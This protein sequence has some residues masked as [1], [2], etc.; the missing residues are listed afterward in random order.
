ME[1]QFLIFETATHFIVVLSCFLVYKKTKELY[2]L[3]LQKGLKYFY[4]AFWYY[5][6][7]FI[8]RYLL[9]IMESYKVEG[10]RLLII[11]FIVLYCAMV[12]GFYLAYSL[13]W[14]RFEKENLKKHILIL[15][16]IVAL[17]I[18]FLEMYLFSRFGIQ[19]PYIFFSIMIITLLF[20]LIENFKEQCC[21]PKRVKSDTIIN[22][23]LSTVGLGFGIY[24]LLFIE[25]M[26]VAVLPTI[27][28]YSWTI[29]TI[30]CVTVAYN[31]IHLSK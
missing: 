11:N 31:V 15:P 2:K 8:L 29:V 21:K 6:F 25:E 7:C 13:M 22:P 14:R 24:L 3:S 30:T 19:T 10:L 20:A 16:Y 26:L 9:V 5:I 27:H 28:F 1:P 18:S 23:Y 17:G 4:K 12:G